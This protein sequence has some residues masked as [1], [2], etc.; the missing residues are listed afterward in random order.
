MDISSKSTVIFD[1]DGVLVNSE[2]LSCGALQQILNEEHHVDMGND[3]SEVLGTSN[4]YAI[5]YYLD[6]FKREYDNREIER[7]V[8]LKQ[9]RYTELAERSLDTFEYCKEFIE[10]LISRDYRIT[11][12]SSGSISKIKFSLAKTGLLHYFDTINSSEEVENGKPA[13][14]LF[15]LAMQRFNVNA[16]ECIVIEDSLLGIKAAQNAGIDT[17]GFVGSFSRE[18]IE[19]TGASVF[20]NYKEL[21][22]MFA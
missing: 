20:E 21:I 4:S 17:L 3:F 2:T 19:N 13:P 9:I 15:L 12:A 11:V 10:L 16:D 8:D 5:K 18:A 7:L 6:K 14:D 22:D 1:V